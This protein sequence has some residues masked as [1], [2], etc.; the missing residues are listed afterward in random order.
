[1]RRLL[2]V[3]LVGFLITDATGLEALV[4]PEPSTNL[5]DTQP[6]GNCPPT[7]VRCACGM[8]VIVPALR[9]CVTLAPAPQTFIDLYSCPVLQTIP[10]EIFHVPKLASPTV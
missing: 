2:F 9:V 6:D 7:C 5:L 8:Q 4:R 1:M 10:A 3:L